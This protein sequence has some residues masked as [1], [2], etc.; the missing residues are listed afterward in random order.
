[1][2]C[3]SLISCMLLPPHLKYT[4]PAETLCLPWIQGSNHP[5]LHKGITGGARKVGC[6]GGWRRGGRWGGG[7]VGAGMV[8]DLA[9]SIVVLILIGT[10]HCKSE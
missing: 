9:L 4:R 10:A 7:G 8:D 6:Q 2:S 1:M 5:R 3:Y